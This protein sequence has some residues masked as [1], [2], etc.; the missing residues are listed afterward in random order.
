MAAAP[1]S[2]YDWRDATG[3]EVAQVGHK[4]TE[5]DT[6]DETLA[7]ECFPNYDLLR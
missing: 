4:A 1:L 2:P 3:E 7:K 6:Q 5:E